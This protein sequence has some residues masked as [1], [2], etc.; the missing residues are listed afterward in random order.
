MSQKTGTSIA[1][2]TIPSHS[3]QLRVDGIHDGIRPGYAWGWDH[4]GP[5]PTKTWAGKHYF[6]LMIDIN[7]GKLSPRMVASTGSCEDEWISQIF[8]CSCL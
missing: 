4:C 5:F 6:S 7:T 1:L 2:S 3:Q 8:F